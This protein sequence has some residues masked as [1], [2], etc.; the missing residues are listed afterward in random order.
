[1]RFLP[2]LTSTQGF[3]AHEHLDARG[4]TRRR[5]GLAVLLLCWYL[6]SLLTSLSTKEI[7][8]AFPY[9][10]S[11]AAT[12]QAFAATFGWATLRTG[13]S[14]MDMLR[15]RQLQLSTFPVAAV[16]VV[17]LASYRWAL[18]SASVSFVHTVK[19]LGPI[20]TIAFSRLFLGEHLPHERYF[21]IAPV[22][23]GVA[24]TSISEA[25]F[26]P[27]GFLAIV[28]STAAQALQSV[29]AKLLMRDRGL[30]KADLFAM[31]ALHAFLMLL[32]LSAAL[33]L[34]RIARQPLSGAQ[35]LRVMRWLFFNGLFSYVNQYAGLSVLD[36]M[37]SPL[38][39]ALANVMKR[40]SVIT[41]AMIY[42]ARPVTALHLCGVSLSVFGALAYQQLDACVPGA[43]A[44]PTDGGGEYELVAIDEEASDNSLLKVTGAGGAESQRGSG[45]QMVSV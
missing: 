19:T 3:I 1:M 18:M 7:L 37:S 8:R 22:I 26:S 21:V 34:W 44:Q 45:T 5:C 31:A 32:P 29:A 36:A 43:R 6:S 11:L 41:F 23:L 4:G 27:M 13:R 12:Q 16:M 25:E 10:I 33:D 40:A 14:R 35:S 42:Q 28:L 15:D 2:S 30:G 20:F 17:A 9:P 39:H 38:S 24:L